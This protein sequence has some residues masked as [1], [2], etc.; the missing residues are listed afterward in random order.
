MFLAP[1]AINTSQGY[2]LASDIWSVG[3]TVIEMATSLPPFHDFNPH[4][5]MFRVCALCHW[6]QSFIS[7]SKVGRDKVH[8]DFPED[9]VPA[10]VDFLLLCFNPDPD[11]RPTAKEVT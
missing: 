11:K 9:L 5:A 1:E 10:A 4:A 8:P 2:G 6:F 3:C 7:S